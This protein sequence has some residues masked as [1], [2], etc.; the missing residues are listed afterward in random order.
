MFPELNSTS[1]IHDVSTRPFETAP[2][3]NRPASVTEAKYQKRGLQ[4]KL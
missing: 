4:E 3:H 2:E 1:V